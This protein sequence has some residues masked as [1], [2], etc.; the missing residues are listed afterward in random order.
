VK[1]TA[2]E[3]KVGDQLAHPEIPEQRLFV[4]AIEDDVIILAR[5]G[6]HD[7]VNSRYYEREF[8]AI[9]FEKIK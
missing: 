8:N 4:T 5:E 7:L 2:A 6:K 9:G 3:V 1:I